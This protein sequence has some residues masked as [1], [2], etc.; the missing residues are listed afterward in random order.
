MKAPVIE[1]GIPLPSASNRRTGIISWLEMLSQADIGDC[2]FIE[3]IDTKRVC[4]P[5]LRIGQKGWYTARKGEKDGK[6][7][8]RVWK[9]TEPGKPHI[10]GRATPRKKKGLR[11]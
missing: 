3:A 10:V 5:A 6:E 11:R 8:V 2:L 1:K 7:G 9:V 4:T